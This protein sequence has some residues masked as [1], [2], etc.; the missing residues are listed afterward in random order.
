MKSLVVALLA[1]VMASANS[2]VL[3]YPKLSYQQLLT[4]HYG[5]DSCPYIDQIVNYL[6]L[7]QMYWGVLNVPPEALDNKYRLINLR[8]R[9]LIWE[10]R[11]DCSNPDR[12]KK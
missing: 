11:V 7:Q 12:Y 6:E 4:L 9:A 10:L 3:V 5:P 1:L 2:Q 8:F